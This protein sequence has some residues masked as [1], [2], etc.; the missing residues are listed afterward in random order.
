MKHRLNYMF[1]LA[2]LCLVSFIFVSTVYAEEESGLHIKV[3]G[4]GQSSG[5]Q[6]VPASLPSEHGN[7][8]QVLNSSYFQQPN[9]NYYKLNKT[10]GMKFSL[11]NK[12]PK[13]T[14]TWFFLVEPSSYD[15]V[16]ANNNCNH[17]NL[18]GRNGF[19]LNDPIGN[20]ANGC[21]DPATRIVQTN[22]IGNSYTAFN[23]NILAGSALGKILNGT[24]S[25]TASPAGIIAGNGDRGTY[26]MGEGFPSADV[27]IDGMGADYS[28]YVGY[29]F[30]GG[31]LRE[32]LGDPEEMND[33]FYK[34]LET[35]VGPYYEGWQ[36]K[37][38]FSQDELR[39]Y[40]RASHQNDE[41]G[42]N[43]RTAIDFLK[44]F[45]IIVEPVYD[46]TATFAWH[47][48]SVEVPHSPGSGLLTIAQYNALIANY[49]NVFIQLD[50]T[51][52]N[53]ALLYLQTTNHVYATA[54]ASAH[55]MLTNDDLYDGYEGQGKNNHIFYR[56]GNIMD[57]ATNAWTADVMGSL[58][59]SGEL[60]GVE[61]EISLERIADPNSGY[62]YFIID[63]NSE[64]PEPTIPN[65][66]K[67]FTCPAGT[68]VNGGTDPYTLNYLF[69]LE[70]NRSTD[71]NKTLTVNSKNDSFNEEK[72]GDDIIRRLDAE[73]HGD[74]EF[75]T[76]KK[77]LGGQ[78][79]N[80]D[81]SN[82]NEFYNRYKL[83]KSNR[84][85]YYSDGGNYYTWHSWYES[86]GRRV[87]E[88]N[89][90]IDWRTFADN[91]V[92]PSSLDITQS[93]D[94]TTIERS[95]GNISEG[96][97]TYY[98]PAMYTE[99]FCVDVNQTK[100][101]PAGTGVDGGTDPY[102][103][104]YLFL[105]EGNRST[106]SNK[107]LTVNSKN[108]SFNEEE[109]GNDIIRRLDAENLGR[110][111]F[112][113]VKEKIGGQTISIDSSNLNEFYDR[114]K[115]AK[116]NRNF[117][118]SDG[119]NY[120][121]WHSWY[122][123]DSRRVTDN[124]NVVQES[125]FNSNIVY[126][127]SLNITQNSDYITIE[128]KFGNIGGTGTYYSPAMYTEYFCVDVNRTERT[129]CSDSVQKAVCNDD[130]TGTIAAFHE[131]D[132][133]KTCTLGKN[134]NSG[135][136][137]IDSEGTNEYCE[138]A[139]KE[140]LDFAL[141]GMKSATSGGYFTLNNYTPTI[142]ARRTC[143]TSEIKYE[144][145]DNDLKSIETDLPEQYNTWHDYLEITKHLNGEAISG[146]SN[147][148]S[149][150]TTGSNPENSYE[151]KTCD[152]KDDYL[153]S[154]C[155]ELEG[156]EKTACESNPKKTY[157]KNLYSDETS[158]YNSCLSSPKSTYT[159]EKHPDGST[160]RPAVI[161]CGL[162]ESGT[163]SDYNPGSIRTEARNE[164]NSS[165]AGKRGNS[166]G[167]GTVTRGTDTCTYSCGS[168]KNPRTC[169]ATYRWEEWE[170]YPYEPINGHNYSGRS[171]Y[172]E[173]NTRCS[174]GG[175]TYNNALREEKTNMADWT[176]YAQSEY[177]YSMYLYREHINNYNRCFFWIDPT[178][179]PIINERTYRLNVGSSPGYNGGDSIYTFRAPDRSKEKMG[180]DDDRPHAYNVYAYLFKPTVSFEYDDPDSVNA[181]GSNEAFKFDED[182]YQYYPIYSTY[183]R[184]GTKE[185]DV[186]PPQGQEHEFTN[187]AIDVNSNTAVTYW[188]QDA[189]DIGE[190]EIKS[191]KGL[192]VFEDINNI[193]SNTS[194][195]K[196]T[197]SDWQ[198]NYFRFYD[199]ETAITQRKS[200]WSKHRG[201]N[202][203][204]RDIIT[205]TGDTCSPPTLKTDE[206]SIKTS[207]D[208]SN[209]DDGYGTIDLTE[210][211]KYQYPKSEG[212]SLASNLGTISRNS[213][214]SQ[215][216]DHIKLVFYNSKYIRSDQNLMYK[217]H[218]PKVYTKVPNG[219]VSL[220]RPSTASLDLPVDSVPININTV[221]GK[222]PYRIKVTDI[223]D[224]LR[225]GELNGWDGYGS[226]DI[227]DSN[228]DDDFDKRFK[229]TSGLRIP[230]LGLNE[231]YKCN[232][233]VVNDVYSPSN[234]KYN[235]FY[236]TVDL[237]NINPV[238]PK[239]GYNWEDTRG[240][241]VKGR[242]EAT[243]DDYT[244]LT[245]DDKDKF[246]FILTPTIMKQIRNYN[247]SQ[248]TRISGAYANWDLTCND[249]S[250]D[251]GYHCYS[252]FLECFAS[253]G[254]Y[255][256]S[257]NG[258]SCSEMFGNSL[259]N[260]FDLMP[261]FNYDKSALDDNRNKLLRKQNEL[262]CAATGEGC[263]SGGGG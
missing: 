180:A 105:L 174:G 217:Y 36:H 259:N 167:I 9:A 61:S 243:A 17:N 222:Y 254:Y 143:V 193:A 250:S 120:Y 108:D 155:A 95:F 175:T 64:Q 183:Y 66:P 68:G 205:C 172:Y 233:K 87:T 162:E 195:K 238:R 70:G 27:F 157:C 210:V 240:E 218:L 46:W 170:I 191:L 142:N 125:T 57:L 163:K 113:A 198:H 213:N 159:L 112:S 109:I 77:K 228:P 219:T 60:H 44:N 208:V 117:Y 133:L 100:T 166:A 241:T 56:E 262:D 164:L 42:Q 190:Y 189:G 63:F 216:V 52:G 202:A 251:D 58:N 67:T 45:M 32:Q 232:Y 51:F 225:R 41:E 126:P 84:D 132:N 20:E 116:S 261:H 24:Y 147:R 196:Y 73:T 255:S 154:L 247:T 72:I 111:E 153:S 149:S 39:K 224:Q 207:G 257:I 258:T 197:T 151:E 10:I 76:F 35:L 236:R 65:D 75:S 1:K 139:C 249:Y 221:A 146:G 124:H 211:K 90:V 85:F 140:D 181:F 110:Y 215:G 145:F 260:Y 43:A 107:T 199:D 18:I 11:V 89:T 134:N 79:I 130:D 48:Q 93:S 127:D 235:F 47:Y 152:V 92:Y 200:P 98:S 122:E 103:L 194:V 86:G 252:A 121:T 209:M 141:P 135:F 5:T 31:S 177:N 160:Y 161:E 244:I 29:R 106:D 28:N 214:I 173:S 229:G 223:K 138:V 227:V 158:E 54:K 239:L 114:Y 49:P 8:T 242:V 69:L 150:E 99:Y 59:S 165:T 74:F 201:E 115:L 101:C 253:G 81:S 204:V 34:I 22:L 246:Q 104:N 128:R 178:D 136:T 231:T 206:V 62:G 25:Y 37:D 83:A 80:I 91:I 182:D 137:M 15:K 248:A 148:G 40:I 129:D 14:T 38:F 188:S 203:V 12:E 256:N 97:N 212:D 23:S 16:F 26:K 263:A 185:T 168:D 156:D 6:G 50:Q 171:G 119:G 30:K 123:F 102:T 96:R 7:Y 4:T 21:R 78:I 118:Y 13:S 131:S 245:D 234:S 184:D 33:F 82:L 220:S 187:I 94:Y 230:T 53:N 88:N 179:M 176:R 192:D 2:L 226:I 3:M 19:A 144:K 55:F 71:S 237:G 169:T 186:I